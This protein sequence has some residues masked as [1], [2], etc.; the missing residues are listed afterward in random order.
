MKFFQY[1]KVT[2]TQDLAKEYLKDNLEAA[3]FIASSQTSG[4]GK[5]GRP[6]YSPKDTGIYYSVAVPNFKINKA[7]IGLLTPYIAI[8]LVEVLKKY[9]PKKTFFLKWVNDIYFNNKKIG[10]IL[11][12]NLNN[13]LIIGVGINVNT[14]NFP[15]SLRELVGS[16]SKEDYKKKCLRQDL[17]K[18]TIKATSEYDQRDFMPL[19]RK[20]SNVVG[21]KVVFK[22]GKNTI[23]ALVQD[24]D[25]NGNLV[26]KTQSE[27]KV[28]TSGEITKIKIKQE[29]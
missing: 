27:V 25:D 21:R 12:E 8:K 19:Y 4:Y 6:F 14:A 29:K 11:T 7:K 10:G 20:L 26:V 15:V 2:S 18:A 1:D 16:I 9:F 3:A 13:G 22:N 5:Q 24:I 17:V 28:F 23:Q